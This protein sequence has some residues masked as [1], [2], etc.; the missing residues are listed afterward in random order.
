MFR[1]AIVE[2]NDAAAQQLEVFLK[3]YEK[4]TCV[5]F[6]VT[7]YQN[8]VSFLT[9]Y[10][11]VFDLVFMDIEMP[12]LNGLDAAFKLRE[13][14]TVVTLV[15]ITNMAQYA[16][17][18]YEVQA[19]YYIV[20]PVSYYDF[21]LKL[22]RAI[23]QLNV[24]HER[25]ISFVAPNGHICLKLSHILFVEVMNHDVVFHTRDKAYKKYGTLKEVESLIS[26]S[27]FVRCNS[28][29][30]VNLRHVAEVKENVAV[31]GKHRL[32]ISTPKKKEFMKALNDY[33]GG[34]R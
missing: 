25:S 10:K 8:A 26:D 16:V 33:H 11:P 6:Q 27:D 7:K 2:D 9:N 32:K 28:C 31:V 3:R 24:R 14:D 30:L 13:I 1:I 5:E 21:A 23:G 18:G 19:F 20:K 17:K 34:G 15:F 12:M 22:K 4:E 29:Y